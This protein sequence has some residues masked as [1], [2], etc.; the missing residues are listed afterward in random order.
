M[1]VKMATILVQQFG[2][3]LDPAD[4]NEMSSKLKLYNS[5]NDKFQKES[6]NEEL[7]DIANQYPLLLNI[8]L[9]KFSNIHFT[10]GLFPPSFFPTI[11]SILK[12]WLHLWYMEVPRLGTEFQL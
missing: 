1:G 11:S 6:I 5:S 7:Q 4:Y 10:S 2:S 9:Y 8:F 12:K 3:F